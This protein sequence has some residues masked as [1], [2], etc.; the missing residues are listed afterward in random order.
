MKKLLA[1]GADPSAKDVDG[2]SACE[3]AK[4]LK[5]ESA[6]TALSYLSSAGDA[7]A[8]EAYAG[9]KARDPAVSSSRKSVTPEPKSW[10][11]A[12]PPPPVDYR[13]DVPDYGRGGTLSYENERSCRSGTTYCGKSC[14]GTGTMCCVP[15]GASNQAGGMC[16][17]IRTGHG[18][19]WGTHKE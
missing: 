9:I 2:R 10:E 8:R 7:C 14:C 18:C 4:S 16:I 17:A 15:D 3:V 6:R 12:P 5:G 1:A 11:P 19:P 13:V